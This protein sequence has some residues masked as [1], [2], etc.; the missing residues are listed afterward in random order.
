MSTMTYSVNEGW[1]ACILAGVL[2]VPVIRYHIV[3][4]PV[5]CGLLS[6]QVLHD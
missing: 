6:K 1:A 4:S 3:Y 2:N 5:D